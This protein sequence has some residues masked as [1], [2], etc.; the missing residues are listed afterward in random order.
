V[1]F[2]VRLH[3]QGLS[4][5][6]L[7]SLRIFG[8]THALIAPTLEPGVDAK[9]ILAHFDELLGPQLQRVRR[10][11][12]HAFAALGVNGAAVPRRGLPEVLAALPDYLSQASVKALGALGLTRKSPSTSRPAGAVE[13][14]EEA[15]LEQL[16]LA[17]RFSLKV[18]ATVPSA[19]KDAVTRTTLSLL[20]RSGI[21]PA[22]VLV[23]GVS[24]R[25]VRVVRELGFFAGLT[26]HPDHVRAEDAAKLVRALG[27]ERLVLSSAAGEGACDLL[28]L[29]RAAHLME[30]AGLSQKVVAKVTKDN[31]STW[32]SIE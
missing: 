11:G 26:L 2:D 3:P 12:V 5:K 4:D 29:P 14:D 19:G 18:L 25:T 23:D 24:E 9:G 16:K 13:P 28:S 20:R 32:L 1:S 30:K 22:Q 15:L 6:D 21:T 10:L 8:V 7:E 17:R 31:A 27:P